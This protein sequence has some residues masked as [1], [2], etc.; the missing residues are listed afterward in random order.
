MAG[1]VGGGTSAGRRE[2]DESEGGEWGR[3][4]RQEGGEGKME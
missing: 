1:G 4:V 2:E 3:R